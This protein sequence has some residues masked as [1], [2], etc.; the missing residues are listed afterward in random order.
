MTGGDII[1]DL[2][3]TGYTQDTISFYRKNG[4]ID[5]YYRLSFS[6]ENS[7]M[8]EYGNSPDKMDDV[9]YCD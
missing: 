7:V 8:L 9:I 4:S 6:M 5:S 3:V 1:S 2:D